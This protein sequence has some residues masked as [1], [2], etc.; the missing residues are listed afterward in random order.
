[1]V[2]KIPILSAGK[3]GDTN[4]T[5]GKRQEE[6][7]SWGDYTKYWRLCQIRKITHHI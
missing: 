3:I 6:L 2:S 4:L 7:Q 1:M 5:G